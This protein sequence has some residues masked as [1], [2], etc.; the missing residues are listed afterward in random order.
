MATRRLSVR[1]FTHLSLSPPGM[2]TIPSSRFSILLSTLP[3]I[4]ARAMPHIEILRIGRGAWVGP[5]CLVRRTFPCIHVALT[6]LSHA[7]A[8]SS[9]IRLQHQRSV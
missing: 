9:H 8:V 1:C 7:A 6:H 2:Y 4:K 3:H 5:V